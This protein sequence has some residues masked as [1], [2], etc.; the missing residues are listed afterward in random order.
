MKSVPGTTSRGRPA[1]AGEGMFIPRILLGGRF[2]H[3]QEGTQLGPR[4]KP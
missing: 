3:I 1:G 2:P 4:E